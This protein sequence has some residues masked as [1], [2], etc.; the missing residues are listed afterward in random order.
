MNINIDTPAELEIW[1]ETQKWK[2]QQYYIGLA[3]GIF[4]FAIV[5]IISIAGGFAEKN[6]D[7][8]NHDNSGDKYY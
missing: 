1:K 5:I 4:I 8:K 2:R 3:I 6:T 7:D